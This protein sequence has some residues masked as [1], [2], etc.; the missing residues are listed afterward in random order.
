MP[1]AYRLNPDFP[2]L[3]ARSRPSYSI[4][5]FCQQY[6]LSDKTIRAALNP[7]DYPDRKGGIYPTTARKIARAYSQAAGI[8]EDDAYAQI[9]IEDTSADR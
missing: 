9:I 2:A 7:K 6:G 5:A 8:S 3:L 1:K 4:R